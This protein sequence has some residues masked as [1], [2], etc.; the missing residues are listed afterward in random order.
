MPSSRT[1]DSSAVAQAASWLAGCAC[2]TAGWLYYWQLVY[3]CIANKAASSESCAKDTTPAYGADASSTPA[4][5]ENPDCTAAETEAATMSGDKL[6]A[7]DIACSN[8]SPR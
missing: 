4:T 7:S 6:P 3:I 2:F 8:P 5:A 1:V